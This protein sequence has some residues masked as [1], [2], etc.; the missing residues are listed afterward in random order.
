MASLLSVSLSTQLWQPRFQGRIAKQTRLSTTVFLDCR[1]PGDS[2]IVCPTTCYVPSV[3]RL[4]MHPGSPRCSKVTTAESTGKKRNCNKLYHMALRNFRKPCSLIWIHLPSK[5]PG[6][7]SQNDPWLSLFSRECQHAEVVGN[8]SHAKVGSEHE[9]VCQLVLQG[10]S[11][12]ICRLLPPS[13]R[14]Y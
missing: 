1:I 8:R 10:S 9:L 11:G 2:Y 7:I 14:R 6:E 4:G 5:D 3:P 13:F 12:H